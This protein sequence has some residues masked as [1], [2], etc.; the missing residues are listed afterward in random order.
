MTA[1]EILEET[2]ISTDTS[3]FK[4]G[5]YFLIEMAMEEYAKLYHENELNKIRVPNVSFSVCDCGNFE[6]ESYSPCCSLSC[7]HEK[8]D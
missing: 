8:F 1:K 6:V 4:E 7:W 3:H 5:H 2:L